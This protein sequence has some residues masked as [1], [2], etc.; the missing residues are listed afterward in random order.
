MGSESREF[1]VTKPAEFVAGG[2]RVRVHP[3]VV[4]YTDGGSGK[5]LSYILC[6]IGEDITEREKAAQL[7]ATALNDS[8]EALAAIQ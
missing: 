6:T 7:I 3:R 5:G 1:A 2:H 8:S 4:S